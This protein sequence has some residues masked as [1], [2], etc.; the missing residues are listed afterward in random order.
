[1]RFWKKKKKKITIRFSVGVHFNLI[2]RGIKKKMA[3]CN[4]SIYIN[5][6]SA[7]CSSLRMG[8]FVFV[9]LYKITLLGNLFPRLLYS[10]CSS[11]GRVKLS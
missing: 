10:C 2:M 6:C 4:L 9:T 1:M 3:I 5:H 7:F 8:M 11:N